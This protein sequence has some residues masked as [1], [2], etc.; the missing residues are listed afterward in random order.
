[1]SHQDTPASAPHVPVLLVPLLK[2]VAPVQGTWLDGTFGAGGYT[3]GLL[4][5]GA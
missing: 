5:A 1:M 4:K 3:K 2:A